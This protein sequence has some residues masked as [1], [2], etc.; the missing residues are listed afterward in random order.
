M[1]GRPR[2]VELGRSL[3]G[4]R[5][6]QT[7]RRVGRDRQVDRGQVKRLTHQVRCANEPERGRGEEGHSEKGPV[8][9]E[10][11]RSRDGESREIARQWERRANLGSER[12]GCVRGSTGG[13]CA[14]SAAHLSQLR[15]SERD[16]TLDG[17]RACRMPGVRADSAAQGRRE[18]ARGPRG[19]PAAVKNAGGGG[20]T[21]RAQRE[22]PE[23]AAGESRRPRC[24]G[25][26]PGTAQVAA[27][28]PWRVEP[29]A[30]WARASPQELGDPYLPPRRRRSPSPSLLHCSGASEPATEA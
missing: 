23:G 13:R 4:L 14:A 3:G 8:R 10:T 9:T 28:R 21:R 29:T 7:S 11:T 16:K 19:A 15:V 12:E 25:L 20:F 2:L 1:W 17:V 18:G 5:G 22:R 26:S 6:G 24:G 27:S 30:A